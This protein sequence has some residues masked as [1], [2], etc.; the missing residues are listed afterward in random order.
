MSTMS[1]GGR[2]RR[3]LETQ[4]GAQKEGRQTVT[5]LKREHTKEF[6]KDSS[7]LKARERSCRMPTEG[8][9]SFFS[10]PVSDAF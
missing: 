4:V 7:D 8:K 3:G 2:A 5:S 10:P 9:L 6:S 1:G